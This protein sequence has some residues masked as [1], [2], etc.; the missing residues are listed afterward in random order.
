VLSSSSTACFARFC[1]FWSMP[2]KTSETSVPGLG[3]PLRLAGFTSGRLTGRLLPFS[4][5]SISSLEIRTA[6]PFLS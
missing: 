6:R 3:T 5:T 1:W 2:V 4:S